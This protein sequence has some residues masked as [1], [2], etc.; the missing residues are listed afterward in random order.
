MGYV[1]F[2][3]IGAGMKVDDF[4]KWGFAV[5]V[6][7]LLWVELRDVIDPRVWLLAF[8]L[9]IAGVSSHLYWL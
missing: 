8:G 9:V 4:D 1:I 3:A 2:G 5:V 7:V 6:L